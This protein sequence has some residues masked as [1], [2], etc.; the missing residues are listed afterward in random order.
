MGYLKISRYPSGVM[1][2]NGRKKNSFS[3]DLLLCAGSAIKI[4]WS[5]ASATHEFTRRRSNVTRHE[6]H[7]SS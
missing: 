3:E 1:C 7:E 4:L 5:K 6:G 2:F